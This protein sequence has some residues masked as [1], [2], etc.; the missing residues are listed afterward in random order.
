ML[1]EE[2]LPLE[3]NGKEKAEE[4][5]YTKLAKKTA[6]SK[7]EEK[8][9]NKLAEKLQSKGYEV[10]ITQARIPETGTWY[11][12]RIGSYITKNEADNF[13][14]NLTQIEPLINSMFV[15]KRN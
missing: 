15:T 14:S 5:T 11:R 3:I 13:G 8:E 7:K 12:V 6:T 1:K 2:E 9:A 4:K 10:Y